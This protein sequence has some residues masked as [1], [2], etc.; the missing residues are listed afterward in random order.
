LT[1]AQF[2]NLLPIQLIFDTW[3][4]IIKPIRGE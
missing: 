4:I 3:I 2:Y 1:V